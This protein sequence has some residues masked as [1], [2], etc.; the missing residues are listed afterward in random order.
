VDRVAFKGSWATLADVPATRDGVDPWAN[1][2][3]VT[4]QNFD[5]EPRTNLKLP[6]RLARDG[7]ALQSEA[8]SS[9][10]SGLSIV[11]KIIGHGTLTIFG[12]VEG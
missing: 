6:I 10:S 12:H 7:N 1:T 4:G 5:S 8:A 11:G 3:A 2:V 9:I